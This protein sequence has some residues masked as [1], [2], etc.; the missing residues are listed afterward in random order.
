[1]VVGFLGLTALLFSL[2]YGV[3]WLFRKLIGEQR[4]GSMMNFRR[5]TR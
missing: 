2:S 3:V 1:M 4:W 5:S